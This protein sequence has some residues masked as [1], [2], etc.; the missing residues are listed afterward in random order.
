MKSES[1]FGAPDQENGEAT[2][3]SAYFYKRVCLEFVEEAILTAGEDGNYGDEFGGSVTVSG[4]TAIVGAD[5][6]DEQ[7]YAAGTA[8]I[9]KRQGGYRGGRAH[10]W[11]ITK[12]NQTLVGVYSPTALRATAKSRR[13][14][15]RP[16]A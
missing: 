5:G 10:S 4:D 12:K 13:A 11:P 14:L 8:Y 1:G 9:L 3:G 15:Y 6:D 16:F 2:P 7:G